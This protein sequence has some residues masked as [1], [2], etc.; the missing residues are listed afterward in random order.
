MLVD[1]QTHVVLPSFDIPRPPISTVSR[2]GVTTATMTAAQSQKT[3]DSSGFD[4]EQF[5]TM[6]LLLYR[7][8]ST[9][10]NLVERMTASLPC[11]LYHG[12]GLTEAAG[13]C[14]ALGPEERDRMAGERRSFLSGGRPLAGVTVAI[15]NPESLD[16]EPD[17]VG[18]FLVR[19]PRVM[20][21]Y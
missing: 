4:P 21:G 12:C 7:A 14:T 18:E 6:R 20:S 3:L 5:R 9:L 17:E 2:E 16:T 13:I 10:P 8:A 1:G 19:T 15:R 11:G